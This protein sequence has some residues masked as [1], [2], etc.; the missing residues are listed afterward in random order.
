MALTAMQATFYRI[1]L[2]GRVRNIDISKALRIG[3]GNRIG[4]YEYVQRMGL[5]MVTRFQVY[6]IRPDL[7]EWLKW[8]AVRDINDYVLLS[9]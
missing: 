8:A 2:E 5:P 7:G 4:D 3:A 6:L 9:E 1:F